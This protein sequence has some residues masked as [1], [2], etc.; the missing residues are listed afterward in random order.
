MLALTLFSCIP[1][2]KISC[3]DLQDGGCP[4]PYVCTDTPIGNCGVGTTFPETD[5]YKSN[6]I[7][8]CDPATSTPPPSS[9]TTVYCSRGNT[10]N[11]ASHVCCPTATKYYYPGTRSAYPA[12]CYRECP[13]AN[14]CGTTFISY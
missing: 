7:Y 14:D 3:D 10:Y 12:G 1:K 13:Y 11:T 8:C 6:T 4:A 2:E 9:T 5:D